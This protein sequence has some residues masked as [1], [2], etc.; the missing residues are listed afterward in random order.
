MYLYNHVLA[1]SKNFIK[2]N[3]IGNDGLSHDD[4][5]TVTYACDNLK[6]KQK[7]GVDII[8]CDDKFTQ[9]T[10]ILRKIW[11]C[12]ATDPK[13][14]DKNVVSGGKKRKI[15]VKL[16]YVLRYRPDLLNTV[17]NYLYKIKVFLLKQ[18]FEVKLY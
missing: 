1:Q 14:S 11:N 16:P 10:V 13:L 17:Y 6:A 9:E 3:E 2:L 8:V 5:L 18:L 15:K 4:Y 12:T 7:V